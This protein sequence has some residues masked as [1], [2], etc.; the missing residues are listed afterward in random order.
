MTSW[1]RHDGRGGLR[2]LLIVLAVGAVLTLV[3]AT[4]AA[5]PA[6]ASPPAPTRPVVKTGAASAVTSQSANLTGAISPGG[7]TTTYFFQYG[8]TIKYGSQSQLVSTTDN[9]T[10]AAKATVGGLVPE[11]AYHFRV[12]AIN[13]LGA[14]FGGDAMFTTTAI[15]LSLDVS[16]LPN[17]IALGSPMSV[18]G[19][20][21]GSGAV[22]SA[23]VLQQ[24]P[25]PFTTGFRIFGSPGLVA[26]DGG[27]QFEGIVPTVTTQYRVVSVGPGQPVVSAT[28]TEF[29]HLAVTMTVSRRR[30]QVGDP[31][32]DFSGLITPAQVGARV[33]VQRLVGKQWWLVAA[34]KAHQAS[35][36]LSSY[37]LP[38]RLRH[39]GLYRAAAASV[40]GGHLANVSPPVLVHVSG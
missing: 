35:P 11:T 9:R 29:V 15:P 3:P 30:T 28:L 18:V 13:A 34:T 20:L 36:G 33:S 4:N 40:E 23:V 5:T 27:F 38:V 26:A 39:S 31:Q 17:P 2:R 16:A 24:N 10:I 12:V 32:A 19:T 7:Q 8:T 22:G 1:V 21:T 14:T 37:T 25:F 6:P